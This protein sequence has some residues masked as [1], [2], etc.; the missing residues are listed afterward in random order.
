MVSAALDDDGALQMYLSPTTGDT[1]HPF[2]TLD[3]FRDFVE[4]SGGAR[5]Q[6]SLAR[7]KKLPSAVNW[8]VSP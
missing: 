6:G 8:A 1:S 4:G 5:G 3:G 7:A 2:A